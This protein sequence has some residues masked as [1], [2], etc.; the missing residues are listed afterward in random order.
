VSL[1][2]YNTMSR[3]KQRFEPLDPARVRV[4]ACGP[5]VYQRIHIGNARPIIVF[6]VLFRL[7]S[8]LY[9]AVTYVRN[10]TDVEDKII[11]Q[12]QADGI[13]VD[14]LTERTIEQLG[15]DCAALGCLPPTAEPR[16]TRYIEDMVGLIDKLIVKGHAYAAEGH[17]LFSVPSFPDYARLSR[18][19]RD[20]QIAGARVDVAPYKRDP[21][22]FVLWKPSAAEEPGWPSPWGFGRPGWHIECSAMSQAL[23]DVPFDIHAGGID[24]IFPH[25]ENEI[26]QSCCANSIDEMARYWLHNGFVDMSGEKMSK[27][28]GN[29]VRIDEALAMADPGPLRQGE[30]VRWWMLSAHYRQPIEFGAEG[31]GRAR[32]ALDRYYGALARAGG[33]GVGEPSDAVLAALG[34]D[35]NT[36]LA[37]AALHDDLTALNAAKDSAKPALAADLRASGRLLGLLG[38]DPQAWLKG[39]AADDDREIE[40]AIAERI[41]ARRSRDFA[42]ADAIRDRLSEQGITLEDGPGGTTWRRA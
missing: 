10:I 19:P 36:P 16:A 2:L 24:L 29:V 18:R 6:D 38:H 5:T 28:L 26:A 32:A 13:A 3:R 35:L 1:H 17:V 20:E 41:E 31:L 22:D 30:I 4:Y 11:A 33:N 27:S 7:L 21:A 37:L 15:R 9:P 39:S 12:S 23:L 40:A 34:D 8:E 14:Q 42:R 25:H